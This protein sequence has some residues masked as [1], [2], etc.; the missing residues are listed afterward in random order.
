MSKAL[1]LARRGRG[2]TCPNPMVG[3]VA[4]KGGRFLGGAYHIR[5]GQPH[6]EAKLLRRLGSR[7][8]G[9]TLHVNLEPC[10]H[11]G[12]TPPCVDQIIEAGVARV[13][14]GMIDPNPK[15]NG[16]GVRKLRQAGIKVTV[17][18][19]EAECR[20][21]NRF[22]IKWIKKKRPYVCLKAGISLNG[23]I[24][25][26]GESVKLSSPESLRRGH[27][28]RAEYDAI[29][30]G[31]ETVRIDN[32]ALTVRWGVRGRNPIRVVVSS[33]LNLPV[34]AKVFENTGPNK[35]LI[36]TTRRVTK[37]KRQKL[38][39]KGVDVV[40]LPSQ[41]GKVSLK[42]LLKELGRREISSLLVEGGSRINQSFLI[43]GLAD[44]V[45]LFV[46]PKLLL[47]QNSTP[48]IASNG[49]KKI[50]KFDQI[51]TSQLGQDVLISGSIKT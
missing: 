48:W 34:E 20:H 41:D 32:P 38:E 35:V 26:Q 49:L 30:V 27:Q 44:E 7:A 37:T 25:Y 13:V 5:R 8:Q 19:M 9:A 12:K 1:G 33:D 10:V 45:N 22:F 16:Q 43:Q 6:A 21:L 51:T 46:S 36:A 15:V 47:G 23:K 31:A 2:Y 39:A 40:I 42:S 24:S 4:V 17:G 50:L 29:L 11:F 18:V 3:V 28:L 14:V